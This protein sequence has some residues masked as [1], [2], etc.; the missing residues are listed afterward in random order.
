MIISEDLLYEDKS[1]KWWSGPLRVHL[2]PNYHVAE[3]PLE[4]KEPS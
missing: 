2:F 3:D 4:L 1:E